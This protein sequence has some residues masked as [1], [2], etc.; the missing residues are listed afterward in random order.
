MRGTNTEGPSFRGDLPQP[1]LL[2][3]V[4]QEAGDPLTGSWRHAELGEFGREKFRHDGVKSRT[5]VHKQDP[6][7]SSR[8]VEVLQD[9]MQ[10]H[11][12]CIIHRPV[13]P[14]GKLQRVQLVACNVLQMG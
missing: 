13:C 9:V 7:I 2:L 11:I 3:S 5:K 12:H 10:P 6:G 14:V 8:A 1:H 4:C